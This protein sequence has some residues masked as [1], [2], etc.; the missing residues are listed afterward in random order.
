ML[1]RIGIR[2]KAPHPGEVCFASSV[3]LGARPGNRKRVAFGW[4]PGNRYWGPVCSGEDGGRVAR[5]AREHKLLWQGFLTP[6]T[7]YK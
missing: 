2:R 5:R 3:G 4:G 1:G 7:P 6:Y